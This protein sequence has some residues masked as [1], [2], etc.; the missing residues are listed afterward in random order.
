MSKS[1]NNAIYLKDTPARRER[2]GPLD[3][4]PDPDAA[5][6]TDPACRR[7]PRVSV[8]RRLNP[9][10]EEVAGLQGTVSPAV[11]VGD[12]R[13]Q[14]EARTALN[15]FPRPDPR[16]AGA[17]LRPRGARPRRLGRRHGPRPGKAARTTMALVHHALDLRV[18]SRNFRTIAFSENLQQGGS[19]RRYFRCSALH[20]AL[21]R[22][23][24]S[25][26]DGSRLARWDHPSRQVHC[27]G[28]RRSEA[29]IYVR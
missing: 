24:R 28:F 20:S 22:A 12:V 27:A 1:L 18:T 8:P 15:A 3:V 16:A 23:A 4:Y 26:D 21:R 2:E 29:K 19:M 10:R 25:A 17:P 14:A 6:D 7:Q 11:P 9:D 13:S 5:P